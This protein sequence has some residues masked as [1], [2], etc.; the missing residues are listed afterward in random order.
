M[1]VKQSPEKIRSWFDRHRQKELRIRKDEDGDLDVSRIRLEDVEFIQYH[2]TDDYLSPQ[3]ILLKGE[4]T[5][6]VVDGEEPIPG[7]TYE[8]SLDDPWFSAAH[9]SSLHLS[10]DRASYL[11]E[12][13]DSAE[14]DGR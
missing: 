11:I 13:M 9:D 2:G 1:N 10:T 5:V 4:G 12:V 14:P 8:I 6:A 7:G 3:A